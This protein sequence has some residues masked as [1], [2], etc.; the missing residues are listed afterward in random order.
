MS[1]R[2]FYFT[3]T[4]NS[5]AIA[6][7][8]AEGLGDTEVHRI[9]PEGAEVEGPERIGIVF[10]VLGW[11]P[12]RMVSE[13][14]QNLHPRSDPY[15][16][17]VT[18][19]GGSQAVTLIRLRKLLR[20][21]GSNL[22]AGFAVQGDFQISFPEDKPMAIIRL[23]AW[24]SRN[25]QP[26]PFSERAEEIVQVIA[27]KRRHAPETTNV[28]AN[29]LGRLIGGAAQMSFKTADKAFDSTDAC[30]SCGTCVRLCPRENVTLENDRPAWHHNC[31]SCYACMAFCPQTAI[32]LNGEV[33]NTPAHR[34]DVVL[35]DALRR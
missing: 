22:D 17:A 3:E 24:I 16:F 27:E 35:S 15:V 13:F 32:T 14:V 11:G 33:P 12:P 2:I 31:E 30:V 5:L 4:G 8:L 7:T 23:M 9:T 6:R 29:T 10:P 20:A 21:N 25:D 28:L 34:P 18:T 1:N 19:C 26:A